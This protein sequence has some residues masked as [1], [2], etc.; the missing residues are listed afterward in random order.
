[1][2]GKQYSRPRKK[3][4]GTEQVGAERWLCLPWWAKVRMNSIDQQ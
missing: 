4:Q 2:W 3:K 1:M